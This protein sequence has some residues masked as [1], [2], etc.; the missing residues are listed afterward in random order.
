MTGHGDSPV[1]A[2]SFDLENARQQSGLS[3]VE[4]WFA[5]VGLGGT[6]MPPELSEYVLGRSTPDR[7]EYNVVAQA[8]NE[9]FNDME[10][11]HPVPYFDE[12]GL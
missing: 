2:P 9:R 7:R 1:S 8:L 12:L 5:C 11:D 3:M 10:L 6:A 4:L